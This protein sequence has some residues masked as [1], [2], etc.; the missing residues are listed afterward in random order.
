MMKLLYNLDDTTIHA[1]TF[2]FFVFSEHFVV[3][4]IDELVRGKKIKKKSCEGNSLV[5]S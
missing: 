2:F 3:I 4:I 5:I 1:L